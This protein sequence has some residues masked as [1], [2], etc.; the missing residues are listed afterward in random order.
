MSASGKVKSKPSQEFIRAERAA[1]FILAKTK[2]SPRVG[3]ILGSGLGAFGEQ[4][5]GATRVEYRKIPIFPQ[6][7][8]I[9]HAG[10]MVIGKVADVPVAVMQGRVHFFEGYTQHQVIF[11]IRVMARMGIRAVVVTNAAGRN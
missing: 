1:K 4:L 5:A 6:S 3:V 8:A 10:R 2:L 9:G 11:P 7:T